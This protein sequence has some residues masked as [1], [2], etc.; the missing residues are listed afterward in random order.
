M[1]DSLKPPGFDWARNNWDSLPPGVWVG[2]T[3]QGV[4]AKASSPHQLRLMLST[5]SD[6]SDPPVVVL[7]YDGKA[8]LTSA[9][10]SLGGATLQL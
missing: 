5:W 1:A 4:I 3:S 6:H 7:R 10:Q 2:V 9:G 8:W